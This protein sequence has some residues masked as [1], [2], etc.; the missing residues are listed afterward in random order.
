MLDVERFGDVTRLRMTSVGSRA[1]GMNVSAYVLRGVMIDSGFHR[2]RRELLRA[3]RTFAVR[4]AIITHWHE[5]HAGNVQSLASAGL[6]I[7]ARDDTVGI[8]RDPPHIRLYRRV[9]WGIPTVLRS[10]LTTFDAGGLGCVY[11][12]G[13]S[14]DHQVVW[15]ASTR[16]LFSG[17]LWLGVR[18]RI[19]HATE[20]PYRIVESLRVARE[21]EPERMFDAH[22]GY[23]ADPVEMIDA[24]IE[25][26]SETLATIEHQVRSGSSDTEILRR[27]LGG[28]ELAG[29]VSGGDYSRRNLV[30][31]ARRRV[32]SGGASSVG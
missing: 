15:D 28:E 24:K 13:H 16:T 30:R 25:W 19:L 5:D 32:E 7:L 29:Y 12:P 2:A 3:V 17:D 10:S 31:A 8:L 1:V 22:R 18:A 20:D 6:P 4:G 11:T 9:C 23:V 14:T 27:V 26:L 21:L